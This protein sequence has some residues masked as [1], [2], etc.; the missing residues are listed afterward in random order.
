LG[1]EKNRVVGSLAMQKGEAEK[2]AIYPQVSSHA[3]IYKVKLHSLD[4]IP[5][6]LSDLVYER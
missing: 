4:K 3:G 1:D 6:D 5:T 2:E